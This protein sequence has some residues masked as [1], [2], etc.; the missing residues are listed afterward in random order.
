MK[1][2]QHGFH[3]S[4]G[5]AAAGFLLMLAL[6]GVITSA[7][8]AITPS[9]RARTIKNFGKVNDNYFRGSQPTQDQMAALKAMGVKTIVDLRKDYVPEARQW[10]NELGLNYFNIPLKPSKA[11]TK[12]QTEYFLSLVNDPA[13][14]PVYVHC[15]GGRHRTG[16]LTAAYRITHDGWTAEQAYDEMKKYDFNDGLFG[17]PSAQKK[18]VFEFYEQR[19]VTLDRE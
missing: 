18:F 13:N 14:G 7:Q 10:A 15:K 12:E 5:L 19:R 17:G 8:N 16:A 9:P 4:N 1:R 2:T 6:T 3:S 11:A